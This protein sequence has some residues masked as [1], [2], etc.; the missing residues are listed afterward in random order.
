MWIGAV[1]PTKTDQKAVDWSVK[2]FWKVFLVLISGQTL[3]LLIR[4]EFLEAALCC[5]DIIKVYLCS[6]FCLCMEPAPFFHSNVFQ[7]LS[8]TVLKNRV[9]RFHPHWYLG[10]KTYHFLQH[11]RKRV[12]LE[13][14]PAPVASMASGGTPCKLACGKKEACSFS[15]D[16]GQDYQIKIRMS[17]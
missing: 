11:F 7:F 16:L 12:T 1:R 13:V 2:R 8:S 5:Q 3:S 6:K 10:G 15:G 14:G 4:V 9:V 17:F